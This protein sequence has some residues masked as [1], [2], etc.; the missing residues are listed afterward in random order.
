MEREQES[1]AEQFL[2]LYRKL[3]GLLEK[4]YSGKRTAGVSVVMEYLRDADSAPCR[5]ELDM[6]REIRN[7]LSHNAGNDGEP[8]VE[9]QPQAQQC[10]HGCHDED[11]RR[12]RRLLQTS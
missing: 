7:L 3:E 5:A 9:P 1:R 6:C 2:K 8:V 10:R 12:P 11:N 4:R